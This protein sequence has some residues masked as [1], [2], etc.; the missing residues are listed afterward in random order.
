MSPLHWGRSMPGEAGKMLGVKKRT[1]RCSHD[2]EGVLV[3]ISDRRAQTLSSLRVCDMRALLASTA[4]LFLFAGSSAWGHGG[5]LNAD[6]CHNERRTGGY[7][8]HR[9]GYTPAAPSTGGSLGLYRTTP[10][11]QS[12]RDT[13]IAAQTLLNHL[14]CDAGVADGSAGALTGAAVDRF[15]NATGRAGGAVDAG[16]V[17]R[18]AEA[19]AAGERC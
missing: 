17:R 3:A 16:L 5:G 6:G 13:V 11:P 9:S 1:L 18:L 8:C 2:A 19:V 12:S 10:S 14:R 4:L 7:H 15:A